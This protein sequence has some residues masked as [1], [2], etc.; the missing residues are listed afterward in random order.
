MAPSRVQA[1]WPTTGALK[2]IAFACVAGLLLLSI[3]IGALHTR[4]GRRFVLSRVTAVL[5]SQQIDFH[6]DDL[7]YSLL[8]LSLELRNVT[9]KSARRIDD[10]PFALVKHITA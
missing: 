10:P 9:I 1:R 8:D 3:A 6:A 5:A 4:A 7:R 2:G